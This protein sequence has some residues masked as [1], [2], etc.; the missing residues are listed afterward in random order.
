MFKVE[1]NDEL[2]TVYLD[3]NFDSSKANEVKDIIEKIDETF[4]VDMS[5][6]NYI[7]SA[8]I[9]IMVMAYSRLKDKGEKVYLANLN[10]HIIK[11]FRMSQLD[12]VFEIK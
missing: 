9:G 10:E 3:G 1:Y 2:K 8:G 7:C 4:T 5:Q 11:V 12:K 6:L